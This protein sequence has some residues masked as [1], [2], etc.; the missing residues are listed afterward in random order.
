MFAEHFREQKP[1]MGKSL[2]LKL[3]PL[4]CSPKHESQVTTLPHSFKK[5]P[6]ASSYLPAFKREKDWDLFP[7]VATL[8]SKKTTHAWLFHLMLLRRNFNGMVLLE[9]HTLS[10]GGAQ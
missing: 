3:F 7:S 5:F 4:F 6:Q 8:P 2:F 1:I 9:V 10:G